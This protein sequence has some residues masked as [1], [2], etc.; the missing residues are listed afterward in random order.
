VV[1]DSRVT[2]V[3]IAHDRSEAV[4][5]GIGHN[6]PKFLNVQNLFETIVHSHRWRLDDIQIVP[7]SQNV[8]AVISETF[9]QALIDHVRTAIQGRLFH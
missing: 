3:S 7:E 6:S 4:E 5:S 2:R 8:K 9:N 1:L